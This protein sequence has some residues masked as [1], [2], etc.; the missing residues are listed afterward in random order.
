MYYICALLCPIWCFH[1]LMLNCLTASL[2]PWASIFCHYCKVLTSYWDLHNYWHL[3]HFGCWGCIVHI[4][5]K[6]LRSLSL[7]EWEMSGYK[8]QEAL[9]SYSWGWTW[10]QKVL[11][12]ERCSN[13]FS[14]LNTAAKGSLLIKSKVKEKCSN[15]A[16]SGMFCFGISWFL[17]FAS[18]THKSWN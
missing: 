16:L 2:V 3:A 13:W 9:F 8:L 15:S 12:A 18:K 1:H 14:G 10:Q 5:L 7:A 17:C 6:N 11:R 4:C